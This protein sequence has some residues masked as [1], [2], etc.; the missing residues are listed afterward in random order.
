[1]MLTST[2]PERQIKPWTIIVTK[3]NKPT[4]FICMSRLWI[5][6]ETH[7]FG[8]H[9]IVCCKTE[10]CPACK[11]GTRRDYRAFVGG[12]SL[13][14]GQYAII[15]MTA[16]ACDQL[17]HFFVCEKGLLGLSITLNRVPNRDTGMLNVMTH[18]YV[19]KPQVLNHEDLSDMLV[20]I[21]SLNS[22]KFVSARPV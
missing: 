13:S 16:T 22:G 21:F 3:A 14:N 12:R 4:R 10:N 18:G 5:N 15:S 19:E 7:W 8:N 1:M 11:S 2:L 9:T 6:F 17:E 20:R